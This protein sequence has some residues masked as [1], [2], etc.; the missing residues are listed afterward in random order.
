[1]K[2]RKLKRW[3]KNILKVFCALAM[4][5]GASECENLKVFLISHILAA[6]VLTIS[7]YLLI[8]NMED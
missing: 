4:L 1:M 2:K 3:V 7:G 6:L 5:V 8:K